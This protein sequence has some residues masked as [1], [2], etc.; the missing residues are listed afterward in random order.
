M[1]KKGDLGERLR[2]LRKARGWTQE[3][4]AAASGLTR[5]HISRLEGGDIQLPSR[6][7]LLRLATALGTTPDDLLAAAGYRVEE[8]GEGLPDLPVYLRLKYDLDDPRTVA[9]IAAIVE[10]MREFN[11]PKPGA[12]DQEDGAASTGQMP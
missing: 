8:R 6:D 1:A 11:A 5:S 3:E 9:A 10:R 12:A 4:L 7:R 2:S